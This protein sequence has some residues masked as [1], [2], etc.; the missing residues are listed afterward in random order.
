[1]LAPALEPLRASVHAEHSDRFDRPDLALWNP[2]S[3]RTPAEIDARC[4]SADALCQRPDPTADPRG[5]C[6]FIHAK[7]KRD[8]RVLQA[9]RAHPQHRAILT[10]EPR[11]AVR[12]DFLDLVP[13]QRIELA[14]RGIRYVCLAA[15]VRSFQ[16][17]RTNRNLAPV[18]H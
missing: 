13:D 2:S 1:M 4:A 7:M 6:V 9:I 11:E 12:H 3:L 8:F 14:W 10:I 15:R 18:T 17:R 5:N 16:S